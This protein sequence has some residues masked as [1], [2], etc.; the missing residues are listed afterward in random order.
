M[1]GGAR[2]RAGQR[3]GPGRLPPRDAGGGGVAH[4]PPPRRRRLEVQGPRQQRCRG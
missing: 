1:G 3:S 4:P 2:V